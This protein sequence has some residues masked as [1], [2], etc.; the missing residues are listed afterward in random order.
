MINIFKFDLFSNVIYESTGTYT[1]VWLVCV[2]FTT[3]L[4]D[5][6]T[7]QLGL[8]L[9]LFLH[10]LR[11]NASLDLAR[12][13][14]GHNLGEVNLSNVSPIVSALI[15]TLFFFHHTLP[16]LITKTKGGSS[17]DN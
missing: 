10:R 1:R 11:H 14:L 13:G 2:F 9:L 12:R 7:L 6:T 8:G 5:S 16:C 15:T 4:I 3:A 17:R